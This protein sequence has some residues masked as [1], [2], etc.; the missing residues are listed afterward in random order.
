MQRFLPYRK[1]G[2]GKKITVLV[3][4]YPLLSL[5]MISNTSYI[6]SVIYGRKTRPVRKSTSA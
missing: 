1:F 3:W 5:N 2:K 6:C 4:Y